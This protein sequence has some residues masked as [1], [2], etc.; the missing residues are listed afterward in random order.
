MRGDDL[1]P[2]L[3][4]GAAELSEDLFPTICR[5][6]SGLFVNHVDILLIRIQVLRYPIA[7]DPL[8]Q[9]LH[10]RKDCFFRRQPGERGALRII[11]HVHQ[12]SFGG[13][14][15]KPLVMRAVHLH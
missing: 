2:Q 10:G 4:T 12:T 1:N 3:L 5:F 14:L 11:H 15:L 9:Q 7:V 6:F 8:P 13:P